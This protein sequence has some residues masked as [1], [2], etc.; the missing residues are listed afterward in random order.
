M[1]L[2]FTL[3]AGLM[4]LAFSAS[5]AAQAGSAN[6]YDM[7]ILVAND[8][9]YKPTVMV[10][11]DLLNP[12]G[13]ALRPPGAGGHIWVSNAGSGTTTTYIGD[14]GG[15][16]LFQDGLK[17]IPISLA[18][19]VEA[20]TPQVTGQVYNAASDIAGQPTEF[21]VSGSAT[22]W[23]TGAPAGSITGSAKFVFVTLDGTINAWRAGTN[24]GM[25]EAVVVKDFSGGWAAANGYTYTPNFTGVAMSTAAFRIDAQGSKVADNRLYATD[26]ANNRIMTFDNQWND[27]SAQ[28][29]FE[30]PAD[31]QN[32]F[33]PFNI[34]DIGGRLYVAYAASE[35]DPLMP[36]EPVRAPGHGRVIAYDRDGHIVQDFKD[37]LDMNAPWGLALAPESFGAFGG[38]LLVANF[39]D[40]SVAALDP[41]TGATLGKLKDVDGKT[42]FIDGLWGLTFGNGVS[43]GDANALYFTAGPNLEED[44]ILGKLTVSAVP[45]PGTY[46][47]MLG[48][49]GLLGGLARRRART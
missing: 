11:P 38:K 30:R 27:I 25:D 49:L 29:H 23:N 35:Y 14:V 9:K 3:L 34:Q 40:G 20:Y 2:R 4:A 18:P 39:G 6:Q 37:Q 41:V 46:V 7:T 28:V 36:S 24:P 45:E 21:R 16:P 32:D 17:R 8:A 10:D 33:M 15:Q 47:L 12:W 19:G 44:G 13:I 31:L 48:G 43:L 42:I 26:F 1:P 22:N 5:D